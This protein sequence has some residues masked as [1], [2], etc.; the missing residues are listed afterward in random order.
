MEIKTERLLLRR[1]TIDDVDELVAIHADPEITRFIGPFDQVE[2]IDWVH[3]VDQNWHDHGY[4][5]LA[6]T[7]RTTRRLLGRTGLAYLPQFGETELGWTLRR[8]VWGRGYA[9][10]AALACMEWAFRD[11]E[12][13]YLISLIEPDNQRSIL[14]AGRLG[15]TPL[16]NDVFLDRQM[17]VHH[18]TRGTWL[19]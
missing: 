7:D 19:A 8:D 12:I 18:M 2:A 13:A 1:M 3:R 15:M 5:R 10:E 11:F 17:I 16:R 4:G 6:I 14:V 9:T